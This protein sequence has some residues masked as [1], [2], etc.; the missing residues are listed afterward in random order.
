MLQKETTDSTTHYSFG[1][2]Y[3][4]RERFVSYHYQTSLVKESGVKEILEVG[5]GNKTVSNYLQRPQ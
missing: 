3:D 5:I 2:E 4:T 1:R